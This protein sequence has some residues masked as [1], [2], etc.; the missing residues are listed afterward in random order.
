[1]KERMQGMVAGFLAGV[2]AVS[3]TVY[4]VSATKSIQVDYGDIKVYKDSALQTLTDAAGNAVEPFIYQGT[5][6][7]PVR[8][9]A[10]LAGMQVTWDG[11]SK[12]V[13]LWD[14]QTPPTLQVIQAEGQTKLTYV[15]NNDTAVTV[16]LALPTSFTLTQS[17][18]STQMPVLT[19]K[20]EE[21]VVGTIRLYPFGTTDTQ[22]LQGVTPSESTLPMQIFSTV[23]LA[24]HVNYDAYMVQTF[25]S[26]GACATAQYCWQ[27][28]SQEGDAANIPWQKKDCILAY[29]WSVMPYFMEILFENT[30]LT[31][32]QQAA[33][34]QNIQISAEKSPA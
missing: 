29:D 31:Q 9:A 12:S 34:A 5:T 21:T 6:Y 8:N 1:M 30:S 2:L 19:L 27:D 4:A 11:S 33:L 25:S 13:Y 23:A 10:E 24:N 14:E 7:L 28:L 3:G 20:D 26:T 17:V 22:D 18:D 15:L 32:E 16:S